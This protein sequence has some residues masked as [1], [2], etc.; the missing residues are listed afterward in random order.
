MSEGRTLGGARIPKHEARR[1]ARLAAEK[2]RTLTSGSGQKLGGAPLRRGED[3]R[4]VIADAAQRR[5]TIMKGCGVGADREK[6]IIEETNHSGFKTKADDEDANEEAIM[7]AY[8]DLI[9][10]DEKE[11][12]GDAYIPP[13][14]ANPAGSRGPRNPF[15]QLAKF[16]PLQENG[17]PQSEQAQTLV[18]LTRSDSVEVPDRRWECPICTLVNPDTYLCCDAC[19]FEKPSQPA[20]TQPPR[21]PGRDTVS[22]TAS[23][24]LKKKST[25]NQILALEKSQPKRPERPLG[26]LCHNCGNFMEHEWWTCAGCGTMKQMS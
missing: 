9:Q 17:T 7:L 18:D 8:I 20:P 24:P 15:A 1:Q 14:N 5:I 3:I 2:R 10:E 6:S 23:K 12:Y 4:N 25:V 26:W 16:E 11:K 22:Q 13:S 21:A 19:S